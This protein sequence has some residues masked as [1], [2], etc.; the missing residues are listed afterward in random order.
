MDSRGAARW[1]TAGSGGALGKYDRLHDVRHPVTLTGPSSACQPSADHVSHP[2]RGRISAV[3]DTPD[4]SRQTLE[5]P[6]GRTLCYAEWGDPEGFP[7]VVHHGTP[8]SRLN[9]HPDPGTYL[10][11]GVRLVTFDRAGYGGS[12]RR[13]GRTV[14]DV[15]PDVAALVDHL[16]IDRFAVTGGSGGAPHSMAVA[17]RLGDRV[18]R[19]RCLVGIAP[20]GP[21]GLGDDEWFAGMAAK[22][23]TEF[24]WA[25][26]GEDVLAPNIAREHAEMVARTAEDPASMLGDYEIDDADR[27]VLARDDMAA[28]AREF[29][30]DLGRGGY[31]GWVDDDLAFTRPWGFDVAEI[32]VPVEVRYGAK[33]TLVPVGHGRWLAA[34]VPGATEEVEEDEGHM[35]DPDEV[36]RLMRWL[37]TG[38]YEA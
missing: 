30:D 10:D 24:R 5:L 16:G 37:V 14:V 38:S 15:V 6:D 20:Y 4:R 21:A 23:V 28:V 29:T 33:D 18:V 31:W 11:A 12:S 25:L 34:H 32:T 36:G 26:A 17:A 27:A 1:L 22:N 2:G 19:A 35:G 8:G 9:R 3:T 13:K 7:V